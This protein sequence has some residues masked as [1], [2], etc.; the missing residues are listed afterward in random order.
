MRVKYAYLDEQFPALDEYLPELRE[1]V[2]SGEFT[3]GPYVEKFEGKFADY[4]GVK[5]CISTNTGTDALILALKS[6]GI[7][8]G[9]EVI[10]V[11]NTFYA[12]AGA[13]VAVG[14]KPVF[15]DSD[16]RYQID[17]TKIEAAISK[18][19]KAIIPVHWA[20]MPPKMD[21]ILK[22]ART[23]NLKVVEDACPATGAH[24]NGKKAGSFGDVNAFSMHPLK[25]LNVMG[26]GGMIVTDS[27]EA[28]DWLLKYRNH[29]MVDRN[30]IDMWGVNAR[31][32]PIQAVIA[33]KLLD[34]IDHL[35]D[36][37]V[38][39]A[40]LLD[41]GLSDLK[42]FV[43]VPPRL[44]GY[45]EAYQLYLASFQRRDELIKF[46]IDNEIEAKIHYPIPLHL[47]KPGLALGYKK[48]DFPVAEKQA[49]EIITIPAHQHVEP[50]QIEFI[51]DKIKEFYHKM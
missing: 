50:N 16:Y 41:E 17:D 48:G 44:E 27:D 22:I 20:G 15:V 34:S 31:L 3:I 9:D 6:L 43:Y 29:G 49:D 40:K 1:L 45:K 35:V 4:I 21:E 13:I 32:Q 23:H 2:K 33:T 10:T 47:Q 36:L 42:D 25:P 51:V 18:N 28:A 11:T 37:R 14:A 7:G 38:R 26:D 30:H 19:T 12:S 46:L 8:P 5:H 24:I 39:N